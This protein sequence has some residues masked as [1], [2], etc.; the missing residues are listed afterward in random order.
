MGLD[1]A[2][3]RGTGPAIAAHRRNQCTGTNPPAGHL[4]AGFAVPDRLGA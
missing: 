3:D 2:V 1:G 4:G